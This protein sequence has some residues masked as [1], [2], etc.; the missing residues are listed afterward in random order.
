MSLGLI[1]DIY[2]LGEIMGFFSGIRKQIANGDDKPLTLTVTHHTPARG[3]L[4]AR[5]QNT[6]TAA[7]RPLLA[8]RRSTATRP[9]SHCL[10]AGEALPRGPQ[11]IA[12][13]QAKH[14]HAARRPLPARRRSTATAARRPLLARRRST[15]TRPASH[16]VPAGEALPP[17]PQATAEIQLYREILCIYLF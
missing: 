13:P 8:R 2:A 1:S 16:C 5:R 4:L 11:A 6:A 7:R 14:C 12:C 15:A 9:A 17:G 3:P 10:P